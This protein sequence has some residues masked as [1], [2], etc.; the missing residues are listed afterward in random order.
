LTRHN[1]P[2]RQLE[3]RDALLATGRFRLVGSGRCD[4]FATGGPSEP[5]LASVTPSASIRRSVL[6]AGSS[7][8]FTIRH[9]K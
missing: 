5:R 3:A 8:G 2:F 6:T 1:G 9:S 7:V 4:W